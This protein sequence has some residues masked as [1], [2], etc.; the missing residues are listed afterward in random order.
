MSLLNGNPR[1]T[2]PVSSLTVGQ[3][4]PP[5]IVE[6]TTS[7]VIVGAL[8]SRDPQDVHHDRDIAKSRGFE[9][10]FMNNMTT[11]GLVFRFVTDWLGPEVAAESI[12]FQLKRPMYPG[13]EL[14]LSGRVTSIE[15]GKEGRSVATIEVVGKNRLG[16]HIVCEF[17]ISLPDE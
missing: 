4:V 6:V 16:T 2:L 10:I 8:A 5:M 17:R 7:Q 13:D 14:H 1:A 11:Q 15:Q 12:K 3:E 9:D